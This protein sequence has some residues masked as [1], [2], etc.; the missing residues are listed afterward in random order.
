[1]HRKQIIVEDTTLVGSYN[2]SLAARCYNWENTFVLKTQPEDVWRF[3]AM[4]DD[5][6]T[7][8][9]NLF[10]FTVNPDENLFPRTESDRVRD[11]KAKLSTKKSSPVNPY[12][13][14]RT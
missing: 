6:L 5:E 13:R 3:D 7:N 9:R 4:W 12:K 2:L 1:M 8:E 11:Y 10:V 14:P